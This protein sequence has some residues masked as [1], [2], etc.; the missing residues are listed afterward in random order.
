MSFT[1]LQAAHR[2]LMILELLAEDRDY[3]IND[4]TMKSELAARGE[5]VSSDLIRADYAWL[6]EMGLVT[7]EELGRIT[8]AR[9]TTRG[10]DVAMGYSTIKGVARPDPGD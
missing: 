5:G 2:R 9:I 8:V 7:L 4:R 6:E 10:Q 3:A 1:E